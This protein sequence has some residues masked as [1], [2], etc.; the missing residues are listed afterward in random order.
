MKKVLMAIVVISILITAPLIYNRAKIEWNNDTYEMIVPYEE[1]REL[2]IRGLDTDTIVKTLYDNGVRGISF[3]PTGIQDLVKQGLVMTLTKSDLFS[4]LQKEDE[5]TRESIL[6]SR[7]NGLYVLL[8]NDLDDR[9]ENAIV[10]SFGDRID[11][12]TDL[13]IFKGES[14]YFIKG[15]SKE[16]LARGMGAVANPILTRPIGFDED[17]MTKFA[18]YGFEPVFRIGNNINENNEYV[19]DQMK[20]LQDKLGG[21]KII[22]TGNTMLGVAPHKDLKTEDAEQYA[23][24]LVNEGFVLMPIEFTKQDGLNIYAKQFNNKIV[25][26]HSLDFFDG[27]GGYTDRATRAVKERNIRGLYVHVADI[28]KLEEE[29]ITA[30]QSFEV[31]TQELEAITSQMADKHQPGIAQSYDILQASKWMTIAGLIGVAAF[32][33][34]AALMVSEKIALLTFAGMLLV[35]AGYIVTGATMFLQAAS[36]VVSIVAATWAAISGEYI[37][38]KKDMVFKFLKGAFLA[39]IGAWFVMSLLYG[40]Q[41]LVKIEE[42]RGVKLLFILPIVLTFLHVIRDHVKDLAMTVV[43]NYYL[44]IVAVIAAGLMILVVR[45]GN[46][47]GEMVSGAELMFRQKLEDFL[48]VRPRT[49][50]FLIGY[51][52]LVLGMY[53]IYQGKGWEQRIGKY[54]LAGGAIGFLST[55][56]TFTHLHIPIYL[57]LLRTV[58]GFVFGA[59]LGLVLI[60]LYRLGKKYWPMIQE[61]L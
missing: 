18:S 51:P 22:F 28:K 3:E 60:F 27:R 30:E 39:L 41:F 5:N 24:R 17:L 58:Y 21:H 4:M 11:K 52:I 1:I 2:A 7:E 40:N 9:W 57:S 54:L 10:K 6:Y 8:R 38:S 47:A 15:I 35:A 25:R 53:I 42:F 12:V 26:L 49:K 43:R 33:G 59:L 55:V 23:L 48:F 56:N 61:R 50:E 16:E 34:L 46:D 32:I 36:L 37:N 20:Q 45:S 44:V 19:L 13:P 31:A 29:T 14:I